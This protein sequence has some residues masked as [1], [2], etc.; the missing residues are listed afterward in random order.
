MRAFGET[1]NNEKQITI[2]ELMIKNEEAMSALYKTYATKFPQR[3]D[4]W[5]SLAKDEIDHANWIRELTIKANEGA[6]YI[7][8]NRF[9]TE[10]IEQLSAYI[11]ERQ[12]E[13]NYVDITL[14]KALTVTYDIENV[15]IE[16]KYFS[17]FIGDAHE[18][19]EVLHK[20]QAATTHHRSLVKE[21]LDS[22]IE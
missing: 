7:D 12:N 4:F 21:A 6:L 3:Q 16:K 15:L 5:L 2:V 17:V 11:D 9:N 13:T 22:V 14:K 1:M 20:L 18:L 10:S 19:K 8:E